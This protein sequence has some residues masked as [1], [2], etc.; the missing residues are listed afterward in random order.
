MICHFIQVTD[1][2]AQ[3]GLKMRVPLLKLITQ[4]KDIILGEC[5]QFMRKL[6]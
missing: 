3:V 2:F 4:Q 1:N 6:S 5:V